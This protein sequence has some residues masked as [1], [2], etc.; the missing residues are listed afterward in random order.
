MEADALEAV[1]DNGDVT[2]DGLTVRESLSLQTD[3]GD[4]RGQLPGE[5]RDYHIESETTTKTACP[6]CWTARASSC[7]R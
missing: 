4:I 7:A 6:P 3:N 2:F 5:M 1:T